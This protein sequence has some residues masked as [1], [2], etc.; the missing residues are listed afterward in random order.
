MTAV[1]TVSAG[2][3][4]KKKGKKNVF[5]VEKKTT[6]RRVGRSVF[7][8]PT[9]SLQKVVQQYNSHKVHLVKTWN[10]FR[11]GTPLSTATVQ[12]FQRF[13]IIRLFYQQRE[14][15]SPWI[16]VKGNQEIV[17]GI[18][19]YL[20]FLTQN[21]KWKKYTYAHETPR[22]K[23]TS[24]YVLFY[25]KFS[26]FLITGS[27]LPWD[28]DE[29]CFKKERYT[30]TSMHIP[31]LVLSETPVMYLSLFRLGGGRN[32]IRPSLSRLGVVQ[33]TKRSLMSVAKFNRSMLFRCFH[34]WILYCLYFFFVVAVLFC[35]ASFYYFISPFFSFSLRTTPK[36]LYCKQ[37]SI[38]L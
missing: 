23:V 16:M 2:R 20:L 33:K 30:H 5:I 14:L 26:F 28:V 22:R 37:R 15:L 18:N 13:I 24:F 11:V 10:G 29:K 36:L 8:W 27:L 17:E 25:F 35:R 34:P 32:H 1:W 4:K 3:N 12:V 19:F 9:G 31:T 6:D 38:Y 7:C 21:F